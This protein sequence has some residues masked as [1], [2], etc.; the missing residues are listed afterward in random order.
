LF[1][2]GFFAQNICF[3]LK[4]YILKLRCQVEPTYDPDIE[5]IT[6][7]KAKVMIS[8]SE[9]IKTAFTNI[10]SGVITIPRFYYNIF[11]RNEMLAIEL[12][13]V[14]HYQR[15]KRFLLELVIVE[16]VVI[17]AS[18]LLPRQ[19]PAL[20]ALFPLLAMLMLALQALMHRNEYL[21]DEYSASYLGQAIIS[22]LKQ[23]G[24]K[25]GFDNPTDSHP[26]IRNRIANLSKK[27][28]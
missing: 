27:N 5:R 26:S 10:F 22:V 23:L 15:R 3:A 18:F 25:Y 17:T 1:V 16:L 14:G 12:H 24:N 19:L 13:E 28:A 6:G 21:A 9:N 8:D 20:I 7:V 4:A 2:V 11:T